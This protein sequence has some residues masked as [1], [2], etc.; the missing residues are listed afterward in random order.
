MPTAEQQQKITT[1][2]LE[3]MGVKSVQSKKKSI[4]PE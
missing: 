2:L 1:F 4:N 3:T